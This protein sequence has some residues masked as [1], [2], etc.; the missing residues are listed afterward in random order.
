MTYKTGPKGLALIK[1][2][3]GYRD[4]AYRCPANVWTIGYG[5]TAGVR[6]GQ[7]CTPAQAE[8][9]LRADLA[10]FETAV[11]RGIRTLITQEQ[12]DALV[13]FT[14]NVGAGAF[15][16][17]TL[18]RQINAGN[19]ALARANFLKWNRGG[20]K[21]LNGLTRRRTAEADL[22]ETGQLKLV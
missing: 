19:F 3:E 7:R 13:A 17:S 2:F 15:A 5:T 18:L 6:Q 1:H 16:G 14:Y 11:N 9:Y 8:A 10:K 12:F 4:V 22:F 20:G 21:V